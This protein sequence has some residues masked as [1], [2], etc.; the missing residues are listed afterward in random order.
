LTLH[1]D[2]KD[3]AIGHGN[4]AFRKFKT[5]GK[6]LILS[7]GGLLLSLMDKYPMPSTGA[8]DSLAVS[9]LCNTP[10]SQDSL[11]LNL[12]TRMPLR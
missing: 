4:G 2:E 9:P 5:A 6:D 8:L 7:Q 10:V 12:H 3:T 11:K 1:L